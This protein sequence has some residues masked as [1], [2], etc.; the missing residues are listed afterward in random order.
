MR[1]YPYTRA[2]I[3]SVFFNQN[4]G[5]EAHVSF[6]QLYTLR[7]KSASDRRKWWEDSK[8]LEKVNEKCTDPKAPYSLSSH[9]HM[10][11]VVTKLASRNQGDLELLIQL[12]CQDTQEALIEFPGVLLAT[13]LPILENLQNMHRFSRLPFRQWI[14]PD[15]HTMSA[16]PLDI[17]PPL[18]ARGESFLFP[19]DSILKADGDRLSFSPRIS[20][21]DVGS[22]DELEARTSLDRGQCLALMAALTRE[23][24]FIRDHQE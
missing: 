23:F 16:R 15:R 4:R 2:H 18:Y 9:D 17:L 20:I 21:D 6:N 19:L 10:S 8:R 22:V 14:L 5:I 3:G 11:T 24:A 7:K 12:S 1:A 13:F